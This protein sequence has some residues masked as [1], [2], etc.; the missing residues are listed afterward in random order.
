MDKFC[1]INIFQCYC[2]SGYVIVGHTEGMGMFLW[3]YR[4]N[5][6][7]EIEWERNLQLFQIFQLVL[8]EVED[9]L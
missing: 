4:A 3:Y 8:V 5:S 2:S 6:Y 9:S 1:G 7:D